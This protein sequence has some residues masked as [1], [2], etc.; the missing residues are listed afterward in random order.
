M[1]TRDRNLFGSL[2]G[3]NKGVKD[4]RIKELTQGGQVVPESNSAVDGV[5]EEQPAFKGKTEQ[6]VRYGCMR[7]EEPPRR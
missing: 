6:E 2:L 3:G 4:K 7:Q 5:L 1:R